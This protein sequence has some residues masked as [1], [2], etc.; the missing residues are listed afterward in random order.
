MARQCRPDIQ[1][2]LDILNDPSKYQRHLP[3][4]RN[5][6]EFFPLSEN[7]LIGIVETLAN[8]LKRNQYKYTALETLN[9]IAI[10]SAHNPETTRSTI[11]TIC[12]FLQQETEIE[13]VELALQAIEYIYENSQTFGTP[14][15]QSNVE[16]FSNLLMSEK[17]QKIHKWAIS[18]LGVAASFYQDAIP[19]VISILRSILDNPDKKDL[20]L[21]AAG[22]IF[23]LYTQNHYQNKH[24]SH[25]LADEL[26]EKHPDP[27]LRL[28]AQIYKNSLNDYFKISNLNLGNSQFDQAIINK[29]FEQAVLPLPNGS[30]FRNGRDCKILF[31]NMHGLTI[32]YIGTKTALLL[33]GSENDDRI[34]Q[35]WKRVKLSMGELL[36]LP[37]TALIPANDNWGHYHPLWDQIRKHNPQNDIEFCDTK[38]SNLGFLPTYNSVQIPVVIDHGCVEHKTPEP[39]ND[40]NVAAHSP[41]TAIQHKIWGD[42]IHQLQEAWPE[43]QLPNTQK[44][45]VF[46]RNTQQA[47][48]EGRLVTGWNTEQIDYTDTT[49]QGVQKI[50]KNYEQTCSAAAA[51]TRQNHQV[52]AP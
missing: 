23:S 29:I 9:Q 31:S 8:L 46:L 19:S 41:Y 12:E 33:E 7:D 34:L 51:T 30:S 36:I 3:I 10:F 16:A 26:I 24:L 1:R 28:Y 42:L 47:L 37:A 4:I 35:P 15:H 39:G 21:A 52:P 44:I 14:T 11:K 45:Q 38:P 5:L 17:A 2:A 13:Q 27:T 22:G 48:K 6:P 18:K 20:H 32:K 40:F 43:N 50:A 25:A 49:A